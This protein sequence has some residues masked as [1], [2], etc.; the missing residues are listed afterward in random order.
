ML[1]WLL[2][3]I[4]EQQWVE[5]D[6]GGGNEVHGLPVGI[7]KTED[8]VSVSYPIDEGRV[9]FAVVPINQIIT[10]RFAVQEGE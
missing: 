3:M 1:E 9:V 5:L 10:G 7:S 4:S 8:A 2:N 6:L